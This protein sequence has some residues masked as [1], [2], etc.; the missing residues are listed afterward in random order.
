VAAMYN[1]RVIFGKIDPMPA[2]TESETEAFDLIVPNILHLKVAKYGLQQTLLEAKTELLHLR[3]KTG[4]FAAPQKAASALTMPPHMWWEWCGGGG[5]SKEL[6]MKLCS[7]PAGCGSTERHWKGFKDILSKKR[8]RLG[9]NKVG[10]LMEIKCDINRELQELN[11]SQ[12]DKRYV[13]DRE[14]MALDLGYLWDQPNP[15]APPSTTTQHQPAE[16]ASSTFKNWKESWEAAAIKHKGDKSTGRYK[17]LRKYKDILFRDDEAEEDRVVIDLEW[18]NRQWVVVSQLTALA[19]DEDITTPDTV[20]GYV[21][22]GELYKMIEG[23]TWNTKRVQAIG[24]LPA[25]PSSS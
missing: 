13:S 8:N 11:G 9:H 2:L 19:H 15:Q 16:T 21:I 1:S 4:L 7:Q 5:V 12:R 10:K 24:D 6:G 17:L 3:Q 23:S 25:P 20:E 22:N 18:S 14:L